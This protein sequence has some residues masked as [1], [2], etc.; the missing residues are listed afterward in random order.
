MEITIRREGKIGWLEVT[1]YESGD[2]GK[3]R[4]AVSNLGWYPSYQCVSGDG[5]SMLVVN[6]GGWPKDTANKH[7]G[8]TPFVG[9]EWA[10]R[11]LAQIIDME[12]REKEKNNGCR[13]KNCAADSSI[14]KGREDK[15]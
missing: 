11:N 15:G 9:F 3:L 10:G 14:R 12:T 8:L 6:F 13:N 1:Q 7:F 5:K 2:Y 4:L